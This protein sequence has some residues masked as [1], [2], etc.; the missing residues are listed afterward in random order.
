MKARKWVRAMGKNQSKTVYITG[1]TLL[2][3]L[4]S[5]LSCTFFCIHGNYEQRPGRGALASAMGELGE[6]KVLA[7]TAQA[8][9]WERDMAQEQL[10][11]AQQ[12]LERL[13]NRSL[14]Q[15]IRN[16]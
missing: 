9:E 10:Q 11:A 14:W 7:A 15:R 8:M 6:Q 1:D 2:K 4:L 5:D 16:K 13:R 12:E 3:Q